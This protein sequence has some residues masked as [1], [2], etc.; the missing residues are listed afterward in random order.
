MF[1]IERLLVIIL[2]EQIAVSLVWFLIQVDASHNIIAPS[3]NFGNLEELQRT[4]FD[5]PASLVIA[6]VDLEDFVI[7]VEIELV[8]SSE[9]YKRERLSIEIACVLSLFDFVDFLHS[10][11]FKEHSFALVSI[12]LV[13]NLKVLLSWR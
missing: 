8:V 12:D 6:A 4:T 2:V 5:F 7:I 1:L 10:V 3:A 9:S 11:N 13:E